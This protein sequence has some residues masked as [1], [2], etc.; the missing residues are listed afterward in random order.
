MK[1]LYFILTSLLVII[2]SICSINYREMFT[3]NLEEKQKK[4]KSIKKNPYL[5]PKK[6]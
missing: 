1:L 6:N 4:T 2:L 3:I 5:W